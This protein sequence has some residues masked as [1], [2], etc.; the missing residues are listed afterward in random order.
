MLTRQRNS[1]ALPRREK[2]EEKVQRMGRGE[3]AVFEELF[4]FACPKFVMPSPPDYNDTTLEV[5]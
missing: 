4:Q 3:V 2:Y 1:H 5:R